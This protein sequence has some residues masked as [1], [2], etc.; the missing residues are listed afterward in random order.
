MY[1]KSILKQQAEPKFPNPP[2]QTGL[3]VIRCRPHAYLVT[4]ASAVSGF[5]E[6]LLRVRFWS[7][8]LRRF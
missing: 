1:K 3:Q 8:P 2:L 6:L 5:R 7:D 4:A